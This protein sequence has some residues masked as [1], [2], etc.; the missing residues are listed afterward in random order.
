MVK[1]L[2][3]HV[4]LFDGEI[5]TCAYYCGS[6]ESALKLSKELRGQGYYTRIHDHV[7]DSPDERWDVYVGRYVLQNRMGEIVF[8]DTI[9]QIGM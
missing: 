2:G 1:E 6:H 3:P 4:R 7:H 5:Y 8:S 9:L